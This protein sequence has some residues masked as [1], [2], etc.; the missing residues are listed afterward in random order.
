M[1]NQTPAKEVSDFVRSAVMYQL[2]L[3]PFT[4]EGT[5][6][7]AIRM[8]P[9]I[10]SLGVD[11]VYLCPQ[12]V[13]DDDPR[14]E[15]WSDRQNASKMDNPY[16]PY[17]LKDYYHTDP[18]YGTDDDLRRFVTTA[19]SLGLLVMLDL[20]YYHCGPTAVFIEDHPDFVKRNEDGTVKNGR[21]HFPEL[22]FDCP[23]LREY[24]W[25]NMEYWVRD[26]DVDGFRTDVEQSVP[27]DFWEEGRRRIEAIK[28]DVIM[29]AESENPL[30]TINAYDISYG[31]TWAIAIR[32]VFIKK[33][34]ASHLI[35]RWTAMRDKMPQGTLFLRNLENH[36]LSMDFGDAR[37]NMIGS[38]ELVQAAM[39]LN[40]TIDGIPF[41]YNGEEIADNSHHCIFANRDH[42][43][44]LVIDWSLALSEVGENRLEFTK[45]LTT[46]RHG[47][48][49]LQEGE[50]VWLDNDRP[51][52]VV[53]FLRTA[54]E[55][56]VLTVVNT[57]DEPLAV[58]V[59]TECGNIDLWDELLAS[60][61]AWRRL[62]DGTARFD[63]L[64]Y[65]YAVL[66][67]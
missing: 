42:G 61:V 66:N 43:K 30:A 13:A 22:N 32:N 51:E 6:K 14:T 50:T 28:E 33:M 27:E 16:S 2:F 41:I 52:A 11:I 63:L 58:A 65:G 40:F 64:P 57:T 62:P 47:N 38:P 37:W 12:M 46:L 49:A 36:D 67:I 17:R 18:E 54:E 15:F 10:A 9:H 5:L 23:E 4:P 39:L 1:P 56:T 60:G 25:K 29:L 20:V 55:Q 59:K 8:L 31:F 26:F 7:A 24:L 21:W 48:I 3:R 44:N 34:P 45:S 35:E 53:S 19:H